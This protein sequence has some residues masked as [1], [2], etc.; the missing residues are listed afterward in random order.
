MALG[1]VTAHFFS[2]DYLLLTPLI[3]GCFF[4]GIIWL[5]GRKQLQPSIFFG[6]IALFLFFGIGYVN[7]QLRLPAHQVNHYTH[8]NIPKQTHVLQLKIIEQLKSDRYYDKFIANVQ[9]LDEQHTHGRILI[10]LEKDSIHPPTQLDDEWLVSAPVQAIPSILNPHQFDYQRYMHTLNVYSEIRIKQIHLNKMKRGTPSLRGYADRARNFA[11]KKLRQSEISLDE[12]AILQ[13]LVLGQKRDL[14][15]QL[16]QNYA[17]A[18]AIHILAVSGLHVG[19]V[20]LIVNFLTLFIKRLPLGSFMQPTVVV[21]ILW[22]F[23]FLT[24]LSPSVCRAVTMFSF[25]AVAQQFGRSTYTMNTLFL[26]FLFLLLIQPIWLFH[27]GFQLSYLAVFFIVWVQPKFATLWRPRYKVVRLFWGIFTVSITAQLGVL[28]LSL[29]YFHQLP[30]L[31]LV[32]NLVILPVL[33]MI[34]GLGLLVVLLACIGY[35]PATIAQAYGYILEA[36]NQFISWVAG[37]DQFIIK[38]ISFSTEQT[39]ACYMLIISVILLWKRATFR[40]VVFALTSIWICIIIPL[41]EKQTKYTSELVLFQ[42]SK[43][44]LIGIT[45]GDT[46]TVLKTDSQAYKNGYPIK[47]YRVQR[48]IKHYREQLMPSIFYYKKHSFLIMDSLGVY[49]KKIKVD[50]LVLTQSPKV[51]LNRV[52]DSLAPTLIIADGSNYYSYVHRWRTSCNKVGIPF[53]YTREEGAFI[54]KNNPDQ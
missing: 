50:Y 27:V 3:A 24:G 37:Q 53:H 19:I 29:Y 12:R 10:Y 34:L 14:T 46:I 16:K 38:N 45:Y 11:I 42:R 25:L 17:D 8:Y 2:T 49:P 6:I 39:L 47:N 13:A 40:T 52:I 41:I 44:S 54:L 48:N 4:L 20:F 36:L 35:L 7:Y 21:V 5:I 51:N 32:S 31:F 23:A 43:K 28:P 1:I 30:G 22:G 18:G 33:G 15:S 9:K 26:S